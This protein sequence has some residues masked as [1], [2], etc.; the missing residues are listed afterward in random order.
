MAPL[1]CRR[2]FELSVLSLATARSATALRPEFGWQACSTSSPIIFGV[3]KR[4]QVV[5]GACDAFRLGQRGEEIANLVGHAHQLVDLGRAHAAS[6]WLAPVVWKLSAPIGARDG[7]QFEAG[8]FRHL[9]SERSRGGDGDERPRSEAHRFGDHFVGAAAGDEKEA[10]LGVRP[11]AQQGADKLVE[12]VMPPHIL[13]RTHY[14]A[15]EVA[16]NR[17]VRGAG[18]RVERLRGVELPERRADGLRRDRALDRLRGV[19][20]A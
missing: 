6:P 20:K 10:A 8:V 17:G 15:V 5:G 18:Q 4:L 7:D 11:I 3:Q 19:A 14:G 1:L 9:Q 2:G 13:A 12:R 16:P